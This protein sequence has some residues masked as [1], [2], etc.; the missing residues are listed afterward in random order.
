VASADLGG[1]GSKQG[2]PVS[3]NWVR[4]SL[5][6]QVL[7]WLAILALLLLKPNR[8]AAAWWV[9]VPLA[10][11]SAIA[12]APQPV[13][14]LL[15]SS[16]LAPLLD[17]IGSLGFGL[18]AVWLLAG[19]L[20]RK[21]RMLAFLGILLAQEVFGLLAF[22]LRQAGE[23]FAPETFVVGISLVVSILVTSVALTLAGLVCR[24]RYGWVRLSLWLIAAL[25]GVWLVI[26]GPFFLVARFASHGDV[27][28]TAIIGLVLIASGI[29][30]G[31]LLPFLALSCVNRFYRER[32]KRLLHLDGTTPLLAPPPAVAEAARG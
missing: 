19:Y 13:L 32:L 20:G 3:Y 24:G 16:N 21:H 22:G 1:L 28:M 11:A 25:V 10:C 5:M 9:W 26:I 6:P 4:P 12:S 30:F 7:P 23:G 14:D 31:V 2:A 18:A 8:C 29:T 15:A 27:P 17:L